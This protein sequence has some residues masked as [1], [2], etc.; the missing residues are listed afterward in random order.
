MKKLFIILL[1]FSLATVTA[2]TK[3]TTG[4][5]K[6]PPKTQVTSTAPKGFVKML[7]Q[8]IDEVMPQLEELLNSADL[9]VYKL[10]E[11]KTYQYDEKFNKKEDIDFKEFFFYLDAE[12]ND[13]LKLRTKD[14]LINTVAINSTFNQKLADLSGVSSLKI[15]DKTQY[16]SFLENEKTFAVLETDPNNYKLDLFQKYSNDIDNAIPIDSIN[17]KTNFSETRKSIIN[18]LGKKYPYLFSSYLNVYNDAKYQF[19]TQNQIIYFKNGVS[20]FIYQEKNSIPKVTI[21]L[22]S[23]LQTLAL[24]NQLGIDTWE[25][26]YTDKQGQT[27]YR[28]NNQMVTL[29]DTSL[30]FFPVPDKN[31]TEARLSYSSIDFDK[32]IYLYN[33]FSFED[34]LKYVDDF[35]LGKKKITKDN[36]L[37]D[38]NLNFTTKIN[39]ELTT[40][41][42]GNLD[43]YNENRGLIFVLDALSDRPRESFREQMPENFVFKDYDMVDNYKRKMY[44]RRQFYF[45]EKY[46]ADKAS[47]EEKERI[48][49]E[50]KRRANEAYQR[51]QEE[52]A[53]RTAE[54][55]S[56]VT[57]ALINAFKK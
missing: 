48:A 11:E 2:Q 17:L 36:Q 30:Q 5:K 35:Y 41:Y 52:K 53:A 29:Q 37:I 43:D 22:N 18:W 15:V 31:D 3:K 26:R 14:N 34:R 23:A 21:N 19:E 46:L 10:K 9:K 12:N 32:I 16:E 1:S 54:T 24:K 13:Y 56:E 7:G 50:E 44:I 4:V 8:N 28:K 40:F 51:R 42:L 39:N 57:N 49:N 55:V 33:N 20:A 45:K 25:L 47:D 27:F 38:G 6:T